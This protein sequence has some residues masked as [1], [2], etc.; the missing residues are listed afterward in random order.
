MDHFLEP[1]WSLSELY[2]YF[3]LKTP[4]GRDWTHVRKLTGWLS[5]FNYQ[6]LL[7]CDGGSGR[8]GDTAE[9]RG[10]MREDEQS[11]RAGGSSGR[12]DVLCCLVLSFLDYEGS[13]KSLLMINF[14]RLSLVPPTHGLFLSCH[15]QSF[16]ASKPKIIV[17]ETWCQS[18]RGF[19]FI[20][21]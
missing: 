19:N 3:R 15:T 8:S 7:R 13:L 12:G 17:T 11:P 20:L 5:L 10:M 1:I 14:T 9:G 16:L 6:L 4:T 21:E 2:L 18:F